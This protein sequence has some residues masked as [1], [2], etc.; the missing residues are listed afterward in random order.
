MKL[1]TEIS[2]FQLW[3]SISFRSR[4][5]T[6]KHRFTPFE[7]STR[8][9]ICFF[10][11]V[12]GFLG[13]DQSISDNLHVWHV[14][15]Y[16]YLYLSALHIMESTCRFLKPN[17]KSWRR[18]RIKENL[19]WE[20]FVLYISIYPVVLNKIPDLIQK[21]KKWSRRKLMLPSNKEKL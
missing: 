15:T 21:K 10:C 3:P 12:G 4:T 5:K 9:L 2:H 19:N 7:N 11:I 16:T 13:C 8:H 20:F 17:L 1:K 18:L 14:N 6:L